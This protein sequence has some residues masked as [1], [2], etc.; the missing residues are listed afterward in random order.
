MARPVCYRSSVYRCQFKLILTVTVVLNY[1]FVFY[2]SN[3]NN[4]SCMPEADGVLVL[5][6][7]TFLRSSGTCSGS[8][9]DRTEA[10]ETFV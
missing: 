5:E 4:N 6:Q 10:K 1:L 9:S 8:R 7:H 3:N 2:C